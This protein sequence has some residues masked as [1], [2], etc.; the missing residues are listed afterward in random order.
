MPTVHIPYHTHLRVKLLAA[1]QGKTIED[2][3]TEILEEELKQK[4][5]ISLKF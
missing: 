1:T 3:I 4:K 2:I 5:V